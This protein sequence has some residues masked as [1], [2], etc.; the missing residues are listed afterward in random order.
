MIFW[1]IFAGVLSLANC[2]TS[3]EKCLDSGKHWCADVKMCAFS[4]CLTVIKKS[5]NCPTLPDKSHAYDDGFVREKVFLTTCA[6]F[7]DDP[8]K[9]FDNKMS[10]MRV[11]STFS[12]NC[13][14]IGPQSNCFAFTAFDVTQKVLVLTFRGTEGAIQM[15]D[16]ILDFFGGKK[17]LGA[18]GNIFGYFYDAFFFVWNGGLQQEMRKLKY[19][20]GDFELWITG[21][22]LGGSM[23]SIAASH[24]VQIGLFKPENIKLVT[25]GQPRTGDYAY[26]TWH[27]ATFPYSFRVVHHRDPVPHIP[28][29][30]GKDELFHHRTEVWYNN[31]MTVGSS[32]KLC[33]EADGLYCSSRNLDAEPNDHM[34]YFDVQNMQDYGLA[35]CV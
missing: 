19:M 14:A 15:T 16:E 18:A 27:D 8:Q 35:G 30:E 13:S 23:A 6:A 9:C 11:S 7:R 1:A 4:P 21:H 28:P 20:Y 24:L 17:S 32:Y 31:N 29:M 25:L 34:T 12:V 10:T 3:C 26:A 5:L 2:E 33:A 22:S